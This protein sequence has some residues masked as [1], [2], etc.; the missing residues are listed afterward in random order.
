MC[1][2]QLGLSM[3]DLQLPLEDLDAYHLTPMGFV[4]WKNPVTINIYC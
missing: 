2:L 1:N 4:L 3:L